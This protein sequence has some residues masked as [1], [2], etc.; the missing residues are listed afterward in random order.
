MIEPTKLID[1]SVLKNTYIFMLS[2]VD[3]I[4]LY[5]FH[6]IYVDNIINFKT[7]YYLCLRRFPCVSIVLF[8]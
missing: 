6:V 7:V 1:D 5:M 8:V 4:C 2:Y 3:N